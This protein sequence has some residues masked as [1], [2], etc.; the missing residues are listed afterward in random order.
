MLRDLSSD[1]VAALLQKIGIIFKRH[2]KEDIYGGYFRGK[3]RTVIVPRNKKSIP[4]GTLA[5]I[6][7]QAGITRKEA[8]KLFHEE[9]IH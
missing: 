6:F 8:E 5:S 3:V 2:G 7:R 1:E 4:K 9:K